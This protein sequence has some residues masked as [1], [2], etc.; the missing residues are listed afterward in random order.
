MGRMNEHSL[1]LDDT[2]DCDCWQDQ[3]TKDPAY[4]EWLAT[5]YPPKKDTDDEICSESIQRL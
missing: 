5:N 3:L 2:D 4:L 1:E